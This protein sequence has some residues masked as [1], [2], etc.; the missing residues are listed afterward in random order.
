[1]S[2]IKKLAPSIPVARA[3]I[4][5]GAGVLLAAAA[6]GYGE[7]G[8]IAACVVFAIGSVGSIAAGRWLS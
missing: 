3:A 7:A 5:W 6:F 8:N 4:L 1:M 2:L